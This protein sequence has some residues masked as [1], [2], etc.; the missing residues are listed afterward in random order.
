MARMLDDRLMFQECRDRGVRFYQQPNRG[1]N[2]NWKW[3]VPF[4]DGR[5]RQRDGFVSRGDAARDALRFLNRTLGR[6]SA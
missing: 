6:L 1:G 3:W 2:P 5:P 4:Y